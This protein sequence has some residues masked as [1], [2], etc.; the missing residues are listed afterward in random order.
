MKAGS[1]GCSLLPHTGVGD[2]Q[3]G[4]NLPVDKP[5]VHLNEKQFLEYISFI[6]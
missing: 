6:I 3:E 2:Q 1:Q 5:N 4:G